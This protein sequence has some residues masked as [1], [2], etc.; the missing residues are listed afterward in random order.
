MELTK[1]QKAGFKLITTHIKR[2]YPFVIDVIPR[3]GDIKKYGSLMGIDIKFNLNKFYDVTNTTP[4]KQYIKEP[5]LLDLLNN[6][7]SY[8]LR[9]VDDDKKDEFAAEF[10][11]EIEWHINEYYKRLPNFMRLNSYYGWT[12]EELQDYEESN[13]YR[14]GWIKELLADE[15]VSMSITDW[16]PVFNETEYRSKNDLNDKI[17]EEWS[18]KYKKSIDCNNPKG[19]SQ[20]AHCQGKKKKDLDEYSRTLK[21]ARRQGSGTRFS[22]PAVKSN[23][24]RFRKYSRK[25][26]EDVENKDLE[27]SKLIVK[28]SIEKIIDSVIV[29]A[30]LNKNGTQIFLFNKND[31]CLLTYT[32]KEKKLWYDHSLLDKEVL[33]RIK[34]NFWLNDI[35][36]EALKSWFDKK[37]KSQGYEV[38][39]K[40]WM[41]G[42]SSNPNVEGAHIALY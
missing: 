29:S 12:D 18:E 1:E 34:V 30:S 15:V 35:F 25:I 17:T 4:P 40:Y 3:L 20:R 7:G 27:K 10:N 31:E 33:G 9:Y 38:G 36:K 41:S 19:F 39:T 24:M 14:Q 11:S 37:G 8:L 6:R 16:I 13:N 5:F 42:L 28:K 26:N 32:I 23:P 2:K 21:M 22:E